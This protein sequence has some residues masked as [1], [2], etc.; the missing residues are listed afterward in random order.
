MRW[1]V[2]FLHPVH[3]RCLLTLDLDLHQ[4]VLRNGHPL[5]DTRAVNVA[6]TSSDYN[7]AARQRV[8]PDT[9]TVQYLLHDLLRVVSA[10]ADLIQEQDAVLAVDLHVPRP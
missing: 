9:A 7:D 3:E 8:L 4:P 5:L 2:G 6:V 1:L 10:L